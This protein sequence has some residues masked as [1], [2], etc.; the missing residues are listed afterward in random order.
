M[1]S[2]GRACDVC[3]P[4]SPI[5]GFDTPRSL[6]GSGML[7]ADR[8]RGEG[9]GGPLSSSS[10]EEANAAMVCAES[11]RPRRPPTLAEMV[12]IVLGVGG[13]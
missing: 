8:I 13:R 6:G 11:V 4:G 1:R 12:F 3:V 5:V 7:C 9:S 10:E 2:Y